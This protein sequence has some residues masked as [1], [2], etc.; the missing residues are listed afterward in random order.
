MANPDNPA[1]SDER[2]KLL[3]LLDRL[4]AVDRKCLPDV[5]VDR[6]VHGDADAR[7]KIE[8]AIEHMPRKLD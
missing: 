3:R 8:E 4:D 6:W 1:D 2:R 5:I 7:R